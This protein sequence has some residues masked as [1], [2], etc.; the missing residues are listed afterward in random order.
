MGPLVSGH[1]CSGRIALMFLFSGLDNIIL[2][3]DDSLIRVHRE[4]LA[5]PLTTF[6][7]M[8]PVPRPDSEKLQQNT[9]I[10]GCQVVHLQDDNV[11]D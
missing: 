6:N 5:R 4:V 3:V 8:F 1:F 10:E 11:L 2:H 9:M 7:G